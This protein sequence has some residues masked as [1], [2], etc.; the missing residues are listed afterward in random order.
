MEKII[1]QVKNRSAGLVVYKIPELNIR[2]E[3]APGEVKKVSKEELEALCFQA[4]GRELIANFLQISSDKMM[5]QLNIKTQPE[6]YMSEQQVIELIQTGSYDAFLDCLD[7]APTGVLDLLKKFSVSLP[8]TDMRK[9]KAL[10]ERLGF[11]VDAA[12][13]HVEEEKEPEAAEKAESGAAKAS[14]FTTQPAGR[15]TAPNYKAENT[16]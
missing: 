10:K 16:K 11:D 2:R 4:G 5:E 14:G 7:Y 13:R 3:F 1:Y 12:I 6:Y 8:I 9:R 15:R